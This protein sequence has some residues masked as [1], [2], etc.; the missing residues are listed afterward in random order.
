MLSFL[1][2]ATARCSRLSLFMKMLLCCLPCCH[3]FFQLAVARR[4]RVCRR[5]GPRDF[6]LSSPQNDTAAAGYVRKLAQSSPALGA[7]AVRVVVTGP[8]E[9]PAKLQISCAPISGE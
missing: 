9:S 5:F 4:D 6:L 7:V 2:A 8:V 3:S 1:S